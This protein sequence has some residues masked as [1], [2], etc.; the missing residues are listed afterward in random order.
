MRK[1]FSI[2][3]HIF[4]II[5]NVDNEYIVRYCKDSSRKNKRR[6]FLNKKLKYVYTKRNILNPLLNLLFFGKRIS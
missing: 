4:N 5:A 3:A 2:F 6:N 1:Q